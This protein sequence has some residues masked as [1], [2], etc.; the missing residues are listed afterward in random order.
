MDNRS[1]LQP[2][3]PLTVDF[4]DRRH[5]PPAVWLV[6]AL[7]TFQPVL[8]AQT[9]DGYREETLAPDSSPLPV[10]GADEKLPPGNRNSVQAAAADITFLQ[11][12]RISGRAQ[13][14]T[15][16]EGDA[17]LRRP[18]LVIRADRLAYDPVSDQATA[19]GNVRI[20]RNG[21]RYEG[22]R[23]AVI[24]ET[25]E[26][27]IED[28]RY[29]FYQ[30]GGHGE[31]LRADLADEAHSTLH[32]TTY[33]TCRRDTIADWA[34]AWVIRAAELQIDNDEEIATAQSAYLEFKGVPLLPIPPLGFPLS[35]KRKSGFLPPTLGFDNTN[36]VEVTTP[37]YWNIAPNRDASI[38][39]TMMASR[40]VNVMGE[41]RYL[42]QDYGGTV[43]TTVMPGDQLRGSDRWGLAAKHK[44]RLGTDL[45]PVSLDFTVN[46]VSDDNYWRDFNSLAFAGQ[47]AQATTPRLL[48]TEFSAIWGAG[49]FSY[50]IKT[51]KWQVLQDDSAYIVQPYERLPQIGARYAR[52]NDGGWDWS[53]DGDYTRFSSIPVL[54]G[55]PNADRSV[56]WA[57]LSRPWL[58]PQGF[59]TPKVQLHTAAY[60]YENA[61]YYG[62]S[63]ASSTVPTFSLDSGLVLERDSVWGGQSIV[64]TLEPRAFY[65]YT[66]YTQQ[67]KL[68][69]YDTAANDFNFSSIYTENAFSGHD[70]VS[71]N[72]LLTVGL[73]SRYLDRETGTQFARFGIAQRLRFEDQGVALNSS[74]TKAVAGVSDFLVGGAVNLQE[75]W[76]LDSLLQYNPLTNKSVRSTLGARY[77][78]GEYRVMNL[79][80]RFQRET[81]EQI[82]TSIQWP[83]RDLWPGQAQDETPGAGGRYYGLAR[84]NYSLYDGRMVDT[85]LGLEY[86]A[87]CWIS[88]LVL[89]RT[90]LDKNAAVQ[91][92]MF[93]LE[94]VGFSKV[95]ISPEK[96]L[97][98][99]IP[100]Y[101]ALRGTPYTPNRAG[102][103]D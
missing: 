56:L 59:I 98:T 8:W 88:R 46:R 16:M 55:Q 100:R 57:Q 28:M 62:S 67:Y 29:E 2:P 14:E 41:Y 76:T 71:D 85:L 95:G 99:S 36:G 89:Q 17:V 64:Q 60:Q 68:P 43:K 4:P 52:I 49:N 82:D 9:V 54:T 26:G 19:I 94:F 84:T 103:Y 72:N 44:G 11:A 87:G 75:R 21:N 83:L 47:S 81:S 40:G 13:R 23:G 27:F 102:I 48:P 78:P 32:Q 69:N 96:A 15:V 90:Q 3:K 34:P 77:N 92:V 37:Y 93:Q 5:I 74:S 66:P 31:A 79:A 97:A 24:T 38:S 51:Q 65:V 7:G 10:P 91:S 1:T 18:G 39:P 22:S 70:K 73:T 33:T 86:D 61:N 58:A 12:D 25:M 20:E 53:V 45:G 63:N 42:E 101:Q 35:E 50:S 30:N 6:L 80:Y